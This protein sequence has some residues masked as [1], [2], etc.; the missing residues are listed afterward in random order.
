[1]K[2]GTIKE[3]M[4]GEYRVGLD[5]SSVADLTAAGH[6]VY[7]EKGAGIN[8]GI[9]DNDYKEAGAILVDTAKEVWDTV[10]LLVKVKEPLQSEFKYFRPSLTIFS[11]LHFNFRHI[12]AKLLLFLPVLDKI[13]MLLFAPA[14]W[15]Y[16]SF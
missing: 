2:I 16:L 15:I 11:F 4:E 7:V 14:E 9:S 3:I 6:E 5:E 10:E 12:R 13:P 1:M 8:S